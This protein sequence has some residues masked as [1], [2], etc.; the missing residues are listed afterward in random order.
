[1]FIYLKLLFLIL[2][3]ILLLLHAGCTGSERTVISSMLYVMH[4]AHLT[5]K[6]DPTAL[7]WSV[8]PRLWGHCNLLWIKVLVE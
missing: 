3:L 8:T 7:S 4:I 1:M 5:N 2:F 6:T